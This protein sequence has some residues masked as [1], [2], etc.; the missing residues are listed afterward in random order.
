MV[1]DRRGSDQRILDQVIT[2]PVKELC[3]GPKDAGI[4]RKNVPGLSDEIDPC[5]D[6][7]GLAR[8][9]FRVISTPACN[10]PR[11]TAAR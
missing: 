11:V 6:L 8:V 7:G 9:L 2:A 3:P 10:S 4:D 5:L 1:D